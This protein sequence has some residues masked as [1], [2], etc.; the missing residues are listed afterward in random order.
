ML[1]EGFFDSQFLG[2]VILYFSLEE[3][4]PELCPFSADGDTPN[5][6]NSVHTDISTATFPKLSRFFEFIFKQG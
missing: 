6:R 3:S 1:L 4:G 2:G 5:A